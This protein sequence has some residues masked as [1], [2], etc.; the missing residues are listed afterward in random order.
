MGMN[1]NFPEIKTN[2]VGMVAIDAELGK[3]AAS[4][5]VN[6]K[7]KSNATITTNVSYN[8]NNVTKN[9]SLGRTFNGISVNVTDVSSNSSVDDE[10]IGGGFVSVQYGNKTYQS[11]LKEPDGTY[12]RQTGTTVS[13][14]T[15]NIPQAGLS[16][17]TKFS[18][19]QIKGNWFVQRPEGITPVVRHT[20]VPYPLSFKHTWTFKK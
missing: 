13:V 2:D 19:I 12:F 5:L 9:N 16:F 8:K 17:G 10:M 15:I 3:Y 1:Y 4:N 14:A 6:V 20:L 11:G 18:Q 7:E